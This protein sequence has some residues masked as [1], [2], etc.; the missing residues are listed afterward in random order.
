MTTEE[1]PIN[2]V[3]LVAANR[4]VA[5][6]EQ[7]PNREVTRNLAFVLRDYMKEETAKREKAAAVK[8]Q[9]LED[10]GFLYDLNFPRIELH[11]FVIDEDSGKEL[12]PFCEVEW[13]TEDGDTND[14]DFEGETI[15]EAVHNAVVWLQEQLAKLEEPPEYQHPVSPIPEF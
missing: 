14:K 9:F 11:Q 6:L 4:Y 13:F 1:R 10:M 8:R 12:N 7:P 5:M 15:E 3:Y 2:S